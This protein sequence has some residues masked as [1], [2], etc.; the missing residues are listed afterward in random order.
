MKVIL[1]RFLELLISAIVFSFLVTFLHVRGYLPESRDVLG[2]VML[3]CT[4]L[5][6]L[7]HIYC[8][9]QCFYEMYQAMDYFIYNIASFALFAGTVFL[10]Y[11]FLGNTL[12]TWIFSI[13]KTFVFFVYG[14]DSYKSMI[15]FLE[16][17]FILIIAVALLKMKIWKKRKRRRR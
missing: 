1:R 9:K 4:I 3:F 8:L 7:Y 5:F 2:I 15:F 13:T 17:T 6:Y 12:F 10:S 14:V 16:I 11:K